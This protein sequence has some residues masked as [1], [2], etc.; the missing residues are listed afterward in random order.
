MTSSS[1]FFFFNNSFL[2]KDNN[3]RLHN[4]VTFQALPSHEFLF[5]FYLGVWSPRLL[6]QR[7]NLLVNIVVLSY[8]HQIITNRNYLEVGVK[9]W[10]RNLNSRPRYLIYQIRGMF[11][12]SKE[13]QWCKEN[14]GKFFSTY[15]KYHHNQ[16][17]VKRIWL[18]QLVR[19]R[20]LFF[21]LIKKTLI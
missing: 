20:E 4:G 16:W 9:Y 13:L 7:T 2:L 15:L 12:W 14:W 3:G 10:L 11:Y 5:I 1:F 6:K 19:A 17:F 18:V 8:T 21:F